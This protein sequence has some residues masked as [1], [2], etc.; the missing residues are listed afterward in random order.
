MK[1]LFFILVLTLSVSSKDFW[2][3]KSEMVLS[4]LWNDAPHCKGRD[5]TAIIAQ[6]INWVLNFV[7]KVIAFFLDNAIYR[8]EMCSHHSLWAW[9]LVLLGWARSHHNFTHYT[10]FSLQI[11]VEMLRSQNESNGN[12]NR[13]I[14][15]KKARIFFLF[16]MAHNLLQAQTHIQHE[17]S[18]G[19]HELCAYIM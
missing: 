9:G 18:Q 6:R 19:T 13:E 15:I 4:T 17:I 16:Q 14:V 8:F 1:H 3:N 11:N 12:E 7:A 5:G 10:L 2:T